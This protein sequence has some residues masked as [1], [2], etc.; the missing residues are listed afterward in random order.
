MHGGSQRGYA[1]KCR[2]QALVT[3][4]PKCLVKKIEIHHTQINKS[5]PKVLFCFALAEA[6][7]QG[8]VFWGSRH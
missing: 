4:C 3:Q 2:P 5:Y 7:V 1:G 8:I 6:F